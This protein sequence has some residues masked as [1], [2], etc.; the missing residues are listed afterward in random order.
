MNAGLA[1]QATR[2][3]GT[4][5]IGPWPGLGVLALWAAAALLAGGLVLGSGT[6]DQPAAAQLRQR[7]NKIRH[8]TEGTAMHKDRSTSRLLHAPSG[9]MRRSRWWAWLAAAVAVATAATGLTA[10]AAPAAA[11]RPAR[12]HPGRDDKAAVVRPRAL[13]HPVLHPQTV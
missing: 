5:P 11:T 8:S 1:I 10:A 7:L 3:I 12:A 2:N 6:P 4:L 9:L 13:L